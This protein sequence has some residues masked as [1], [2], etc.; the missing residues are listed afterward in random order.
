M[1]F[2][3][4]IV[5]VEIND[6]SLRGLQESGKIAIVT[7]LRDEEVSSTQFAPRT[8]Q[9]RVKGVSQGLVSPYE[10]RSVFALQ[11]VSSEAYLA[12]NSSDRTVMLLDEQFP[13]PDAFCFKFAAEHG[14]FS[15]EV[16][17]SIQPLDQGPVK[18]AV[19]PGITLSL[20]IRAMQTSSE[21]LKA[22][23]SQ[24]NQQLSIIAA[25]QQ[26]NAVTRDESDDIHA[27]HDPLS[28]DHSAHSVPIKRGKDSDGGREKSYLD[29]EKMIARAKEMIDSGDLKVAKEALGRFYDDGA[30]DNACV[31]DK[32]DRSPQTTSQR[33][34]KRVF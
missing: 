9:F 8:N 15:V 21:K 22:V 25:L 3:N 31:G 30:Y 19:D 4:L 34:L 32:T 2:N 6:T 24:Y 17:C 20:C 27:N 12:I 13:P 28:E 18:D 14:P 23:E 10:E 26:A 5:S 29:S 16:P 7:T 11:S 1:D 33:Q